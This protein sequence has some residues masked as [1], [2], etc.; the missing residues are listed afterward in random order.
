[1]AMLCSMTAALPVLILRKT[2]V[3]RAGRKTML[4]R[5]GHH[6]VQSLGV[7]A[8]S[9]LKA[10][11]NRKFAGVGEKVRCRKQGI[12]WITS[13]GLVE[14]QAT[15]SAIQCVGHAPRRPHAKTDI[16]H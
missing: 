8:D 4:R 9:F 13:I 1:M 3:T 15:G 10:V 14:E 16:Q 11:V 2:D 7:F 5:D 6:R 12:S